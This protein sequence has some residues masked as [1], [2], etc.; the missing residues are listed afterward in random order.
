MWNKKETKRV[1]GNADILSHPAGNN[2]LCL[3]VT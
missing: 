3:E 2:I 1:D